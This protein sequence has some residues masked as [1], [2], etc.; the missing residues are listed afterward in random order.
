MINTKHVLKVVSAWV[1][2]VYIVCF[3]GVA[4]FPYS[5][6]L[7]MKYA[8][9]AEISTGVDYLNVGSFVYGLVVWNLV[10][11]LAIWL[12]AALFNKIKQ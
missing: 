8:L 9:H 11:L 2:V 12:F 6:F 3:A 1:S 7:F 5:R 10:A 4:I